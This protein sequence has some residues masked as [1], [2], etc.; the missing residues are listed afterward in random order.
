MVLWD[1]RHRPRVPDSPV[2]VGSLTSVLPLADCG[3]EVACGTDGGEVLVVDLRRPALPTLQYTPVVKRV[4]LQA[5][6]ASRIVQAGLVEAAALGGP[7][8]AHCLGAGRHLR[9]EKHWGKTAEHWVPCAPCRHTGYTPI[10]R[11]SYAVHC[12]VPSPLGGHRCV[13]HTATGITVELDLKTGR[14]H[15]LH[16]P[17]PLRLPVICGIAVSGAGPPVVCVPSADACVALVDWTHSNS[18]AP[19]LRDFPL[20]APAVCAAFHPRME[21]LV[22]G[23]LGGAVFS[24]GWQPHKGMCP[25][26]LP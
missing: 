21:A 3:Y 22:V 24:V 18:S 11:C 1:R 14:T 15:Q 10:T 4:D 25:Y 17:P 2:A 5:V 12:L 20:P 7:K 23:T 6:I 13:A 9:V 16:C 26:P 8:C 19:F